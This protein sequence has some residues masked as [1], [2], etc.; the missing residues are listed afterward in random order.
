MALLDHSSID[1]VFR[2]IVSTK[3]GEQLRKSR[4]LSYTRVHEL[5]LSKLSSLGF[6]TRKF[7][8]HSFRA[9]GATAAANAG[10]T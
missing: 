1:C 3:S 8:M 10:G 7:D 4:M 6:D 5:M 2:G 9:G